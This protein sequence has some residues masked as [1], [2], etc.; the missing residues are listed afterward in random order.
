[1]HEE[2]AQYPGPSARAEPGSGTGPS[3]RGGSLGAIW[4]GPNCRLQGV[5]L[6]VPTPA[7][8]GLAR[9]STLSLCQ[10]YQWV[11]EWAGSQ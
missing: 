10:L 11:S 4:P 3:T 2:E 6:A 8:P 1:M 9:W 7:L 5:T